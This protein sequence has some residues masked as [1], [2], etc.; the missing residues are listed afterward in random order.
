MKAPVRLDEAASGEERQPN[1]VRG[2][3]HFADLISMCD[4]KSSLPKLFRPTEIDTQEHILPSVDASNPGH[5][6]KIASR[7]SPASTGMM[8]TPAFQAG[9]I[10]PKL[11]RDLRHRDQSF[12]GP[13]PEAAFGYG[14]LKNFSKSSEVGCL[15]DCS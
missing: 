6:S 12:A 9:H 7:K 5:T 1:E 10:F 2:A 13:D 3:Y 8:S 15:E 4:K 11:T 14:N